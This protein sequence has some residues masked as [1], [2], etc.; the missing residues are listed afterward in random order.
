MPR[1]RFLRFRDI[2]FSKPRLGFLSSTPR[3]HCSLT[4]FTRFLNYNLR[5][6]SSTPRFS[7]FRWYWTRFP[8]FR[9]IHCSKQG[10]GFHSS[11]SGF[12]STLIRL[13]RFHSYTPRFLGSTPSSFRFSWQN[14]LTWYIHGLLSLSKFWCGLSGAQSPQGLQ[15]PSYV[16]FGDISTPRV[17]RVIPGRGELI[18]GKG[19]LD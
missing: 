9:D 17:H 6:L 11:T 19:T 4:R 8:R 7:K 1:T 3:F 10:L 16:T 18:W 13:L 14:S 15:E 12:H 2:Q 5:F